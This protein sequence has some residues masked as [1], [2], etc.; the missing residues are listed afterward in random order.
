[1]AALTAIL[2]GYLTLR[3]VFVAL[4]APTLAQDGAYLDALLTGLDVLG[5]TS[6]TSVVRQVDSDPSQPIFSLSLSDFTIPY[7]LFVPDNDAC[8]CF[9]E[10]LSLAP[11][12]KKK[13]F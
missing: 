3:L 7:T 6:F 4:A 5:L 13:I 9:V 12:T 8:E 11:L 2:F 10:F 1:M